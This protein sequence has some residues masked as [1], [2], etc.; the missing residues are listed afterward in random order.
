MPV[1]LLGAV[2]A[3]VDVIGGFHKFIR[4]PR[5]AARTENGVAVAERSVDVL[6]PPAPVPELYDVDAPRVELRHDALQHRRRVVDARRE[7]EKEAA[8]TLAEQVGDEA[9]VAN[10]RLRADEPFHVRDQLADL[11]RVDELAPA[12]LTTP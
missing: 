3:D 4:Q 9:E 5:P 11:D 2:E 1:P 7:L 8:E 10:E 6:V 12:H